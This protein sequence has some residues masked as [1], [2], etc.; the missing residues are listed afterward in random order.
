MS[1]L[2]TQN[3]TIVGAGNIVEFENHYKCDDVVVPKSV[4]G[5]CTI[6]DGVLPVAPVPT[7]AAV[8]MRQARLALLQAGLLATTNS[9][10]AAIPGTAGDAARIEW[11][12]ATEVRR[13]S[14]LVAAL[15]PMLTMTDAQI[16]AL[17]VAASGL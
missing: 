17:F 6:V 7:P 12:Y 10:I 8:S 9:T 11:E 2:K 4:V 14:L 1:L 3:G 16:D 5:V 15:T 13:D